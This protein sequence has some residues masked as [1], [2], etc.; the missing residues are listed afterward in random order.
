MHLL[1]SHMSFSAGGRRTHY[2]QPDV[3][4]DQDLGVDW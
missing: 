4:R 3:G 2:P 1:R